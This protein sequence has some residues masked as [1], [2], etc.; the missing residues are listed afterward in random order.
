MS[1]QKQY[2]FFHFSPQH[3]VKFTG[4]VHVFIINYFVNYYHASN[5]KSQQLQLLQFKNTGTIS[6]DIIFKL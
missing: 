5:I 3:E 4:L 1:K 6:L 2:F